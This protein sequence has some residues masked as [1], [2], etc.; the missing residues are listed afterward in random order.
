MDEETLEA[1]RRLER[2]RQDQ[3]IDALHQERLRARMRFMREE[4]L[5]DPAA[6]RL[7]WLLEH[8]DQ[9][10]P[11]AQAAVLEEIVQQVNLWSNGDRW[12][13]IAQLL[14]RFIERLPDSRRDRLVDQL[15]KV[16]VEYG[17]GDLAEEMPGPLAVPSSDRIP[18]GEQPHL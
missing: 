17:Q 15:G 2:A 7:Y 10:N 8:P 18:A 5:R 14:H 11:Q 12:I 16:F 1:A 9:A 6:A 13:T 4:A 3:G